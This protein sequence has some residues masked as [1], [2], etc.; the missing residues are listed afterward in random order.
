VF[1]KFLLWWH[2]LLLLLQRWR[3]LLGPCAIPYRHRCIAVISRHLLVAWGLLDLL[4]LVGGSFWHQ[5]AAAIQPGRC[6]VCPL[7]PG[8][9]GQLLLL[10]LPLMCWVLLDRQ[11]HLRRQRW[12]GSWG[13]R[14]RWLNVCCGFRLD[15]WLLLLLL[16][17]PIQRCVPMCSVTISLCMGLPWRWMLPPSAV[18][19]RR[20]VRVAVDSVGRL[21]LVD[22][23]STG[24]FTVF[25]C[26][27]WHWTAALG[28][29]LSRRIACPLQLGR[30]LPLLL[31]LLQRRR[32]RPTASSQHATRLAGVRTNMLSCGAA[33]CRLACCF[34]AAHSRR[35][36]ARPRLR[37]GHAFLLLALGLR[38]GFHAC[39]QLLGI[40]HRAQVATIFLHDLALMVVTAVLLA[41]LGA[42]DLPV[43]IL[44]ADA[45]FLH[46]AGQVEALQGAG[47]GSRTRRRSARR[48]HINLAC[49]ALAD[50]V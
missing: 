34:S 32:L 47:G 10:L 7:L 48:Q 18:G 39:R 12:T 1:V 4:N 15:G 14:R 37:G 2:L 19:W 25:S 40:H 38:G 30:L 41:V 42:E 21:R 17:L 24:I 9:L 49:R 23:S 45:G 16:L 46:G 33:G 31:L 29:P 5:A 44:E 35:L 8:W 3:R 28:P 27:L 36:L 22:W 6:I 43:K 26:S 50:T 11:A 20:C 13:L